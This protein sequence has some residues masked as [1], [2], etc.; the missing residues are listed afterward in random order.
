M[1]TSP[2][3]RSY[4]AAFPARFVTKGR[5]SLPGARVYLNKDSDEFRQLL[6]ALPL[7]IGSGNGFLGQFVGAK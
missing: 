1:P 7:C 3:L 6:S 4:D 5:D 2:R